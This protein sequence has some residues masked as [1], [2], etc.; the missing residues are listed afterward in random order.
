MLG[1]SPIVWTNLHFTEIRGP[2]LSYAT[3]GFVD[4]LDR[5]DAILADMNLV[6][7]DAEVNF[8]VAAL[9]ESCNM[10]P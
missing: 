4:A 8:A 10:V 9:N 5:D 2:I 6:D 7:G 1:L 3:T